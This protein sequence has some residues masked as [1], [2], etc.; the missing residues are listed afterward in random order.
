MGATSKVAHDFEDQLECSHRNLILPAE[1]INNPFPLEVSNLQAKFDVP[2][3]TIT[4]QS[5]TK[6]V[7]GQHRIVTVLAKTYSNNGISPGQ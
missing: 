6:T 3:D 2:K 7:S 4:D 5:S 1:L